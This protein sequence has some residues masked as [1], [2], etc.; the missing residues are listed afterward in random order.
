MLLSKNLE[1]FI[2]L[3]NEGITIPKAVYK[4]G[5]F[6]PFARILSRK[7]NRIYAPNDML[8][9]TSGARSVFMLPNIGCA[10]NHSNL[11]RNFN[12]HKSPAKSLYEHWD[13][14]KEIANSEVIASDWRSCVMYFSQKWLDKLEN[15]KAWL[16]L[17]LYLHQLAWQYSEYQRNHFYYDIAFSII[18]K[19][20]NLKPNP[21]LVDTAR[22][23][24]VTALGAAP[25]FIPVCN[26]E[27]LPLD[28]IQQVFVESYGLKKYSPTIMQPTHFN[29][30]EDGLPIYYSLQNPSTHVF[31]PKSREVSS[32][33]F[34][35]RELEHITRVFV[36]ELGSDEGL[37][38][39]TVMSHVARS[40]KF[41]YFHNKEDRHRVVLP[42]SE[43][44]T[45]DDRFNII[46][47]KFKTKEARFSS[48]APFVR[49]CI[50]VSTN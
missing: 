47:P 2:D 31:S 9:L 8:T 15:D 6:F 32:T 42:S 35:M 46:N 20:R 1:L 27:A 33:L 45:H 49:G 30:E 24:F 25:G 11:Q 14:F 44:A 41:K 29:F 12:V 43:I 7:S 36:E 10:T 40:V 4:P 19:K 17:K 38:S 28:L 50:S 16:P 26:D 5:A 39:N 3:K 23:L 21:Y 48:D 22:H 18:Q 37:C 13:I 34:E